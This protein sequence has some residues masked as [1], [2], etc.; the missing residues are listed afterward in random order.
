MNNLL[1]KQFNDAD[2]RYLTDSEIQPLESYLESYRA[3]LATYQLLQEKSDQLVLQTLRQMIQTDREVVQR[4][5]EICR[6]DLN[7]VLR[8]IAASILRDSEDKFREQ[9]LLWL[10]TIMIALNKQEQSAKAYMLLQELINKTFPVEH[11]QLIR[12]YLDLVISALRVNTP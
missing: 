8:Y 1:Q 12:P 3:R 9:L 11:V 5:G 10:Q 7:D 2:G 6:R 4:Y